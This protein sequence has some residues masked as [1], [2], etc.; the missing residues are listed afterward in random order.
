MDDPLSQVDTKHEAEED[1]SHVGTPYS[2]TPVKLETL[3]LNPH[4]QPS[5]NP[6]NFSY[7][8]RQSH[9]EPPSLDETPSSGLNP[10]ITPN[11]TGEDVPSASQPE[12]E[13]TDPTEFLDVDSQDQRTSPS[14]SE[15]SS[16][17][18]QSQEESPTISKAQHFEIIGGIDEEFFPSVFYRSHGGFYRLPLTPGLIDIGSVVRAIYSERYW[19]RRPEPPN[20]KQVIDFFLKAKDMPKYH[21]PGG[22]LNQYQLD[23]LISLDQIHYLNRLVDMTSWLGHRFRFGNDVCLCQL[24]NFNALPELCVGIY[25]LDLATSGNGKT[26]R[27]VVD[28][29]RL[30]GLMLDFAC[31]KG[32]CECPNVLRHEDDA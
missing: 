9:G 16:S 10:Q 20:A 32:E 2:D 13:P 7:S 27:E 4:L 1:W 8:S 12:D 23:P 11:T 5:S 21:I 26:T 18:S 6:A 30:D 19:F 31:G 25:Y 22:L 17:D 3:T 29:D 28:F 24:Q 14:P 15:K